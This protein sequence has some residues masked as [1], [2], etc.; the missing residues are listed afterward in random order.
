MNEIYNK[1]SE[2]SYYSQNDKILFHWLYIFNRL[3]NGL[4]IYKLYSDEVN[5]RA[6]WNSLVD[7]D[8]QLGENIKL[9][10]KIKFLL[11]ASDT[12]YDFENK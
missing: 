10:Y 7:K 3:Y 11:L 8:V 2:S 4:Y 12:M 1:I 9:D 6:Y 5:I